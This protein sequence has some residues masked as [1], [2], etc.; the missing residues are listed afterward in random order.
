MINTFYQLILI[1]FD[2]I[3]TNRIHEIRNPVIF[4]HLHTL[5]VWMQ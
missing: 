4:I 5:I 2:I 3:K 1:I